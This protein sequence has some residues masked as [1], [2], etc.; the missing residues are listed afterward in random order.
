MSAQVRDADKDEVVHEV[1]R[2]TVA[3]ETMLDVT[4]RLV[5]FL[6]P[7]VLI[8]DLNTHQVYPS[9]GSIEFKNVEG[10]TFYKE[11]SLYDSCVA[12]G[13][14]PCPL[15]CVSPT[16]EGMG[17]LLRDLDGHEARRVMQSLRDGLRMKASSIPA[18]LPPN[19]KQAKES[20]T[21]RRAS[22]ARRDARRG[23]AVR[24]APPSRV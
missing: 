3:P 23:R 21:R 14:G 9:F 8:E 4:V 11:K 6:W 10:L 20:L 2:T 19:R 24:R 12:T 7:R 22:R 18:A 1:I 17:V 15:L 13:T 16:S 5:M